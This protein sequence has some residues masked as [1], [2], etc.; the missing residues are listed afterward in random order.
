MIERR[1][2]LP[3]FSSDR[4]RFETHSGAELPLGVSR[5]PLRSD[6]ESGV[7]TVISGLGKTK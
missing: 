4:E 7:M 3:K 5:C 6:A 1:F 2:L